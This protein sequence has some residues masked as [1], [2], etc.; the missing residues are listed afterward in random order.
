MGNLVGDVVEA[1][2]EEV[3]EHD[4]GDR[5][6]A[7]HRRAH[8]RAQDRLLGDRRV[9]HAQGPELLEQADGRLEHAARLGHVLAEEHDVG[10]ARHLLRDAARDGV[11]IGQFRHAAASVGIDVGGEDIERR[12][13][14]RLALS[15]ASSTLRLHSVS[16]AAIVAL[17]DAELPSRS[18]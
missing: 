11:A 9:A 16:I 18:R 1:D 8:G 2:R 10:I 14:R 3:R 13:R 15:V 5:L 6:Q 4:L 17:G 7:G 12:R